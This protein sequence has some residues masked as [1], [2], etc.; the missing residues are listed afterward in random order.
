M[1]A[2]LDRPFRALRPEAAV[3]HLTPA[4]W[5]T[6]NARLVAKAIG[7]FAHELLLAPRPAAA[8]GDPPDRFASY[9]LPITPASAIAF[10]PGGSRS[11]IGGSTRRQ[12]VDIDR[13]CQT[14]RPR[15]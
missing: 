11:T 7:E 15:R 13:R 1:T 10:V 3:D 14:R 8:D 2:A 12:S 5:R 4:V 6:V 9:E